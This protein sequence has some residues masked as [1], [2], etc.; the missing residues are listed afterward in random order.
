MHAS[1]LRRR[2]AST[3]SGSSRVRD[4]EARRARWFILGL[5]RT[6]NWKNPQGFTR[7]WLVF[8]F[9]ARLLKGT[10]E[11]RNFHL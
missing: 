3:K 7:H 9:S 6:H 5:G 1:L 2:T 10:S 11:E 4:G 8:P